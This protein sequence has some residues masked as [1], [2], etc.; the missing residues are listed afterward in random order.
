M[1]SVI[2]LVVTC[3]LMLAALVFWVVCRAAASIEPVQ[4]DCGEYDSG[5]RDVP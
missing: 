1:L 5:G 3:I 4:P 2:G